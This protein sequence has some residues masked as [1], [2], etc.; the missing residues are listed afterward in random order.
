MPTLVVPMPNTDDFTA[1][2]LADI[3]EFVRV[4]VDRWLTAHG[5]PPG[6]T[7]VVGRG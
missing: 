5:R 4:G 1:A 7:V 6:T 2:E 3:A